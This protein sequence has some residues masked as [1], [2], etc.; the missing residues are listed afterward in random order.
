MLKVCLKVDSGFSTWVIVETSDDASR[1]VRDYIEKNDIGSRAWMGGDVVDDDGNYVTW[2]SYNGR[3]W[4][5]STKHGREA[6][7]RYLS[8]LDKSQ[9]IDMSMAQDDRYTKLRGYHSGLTRGRCGI[10]SE[11]ELRKLIVESELQLRRRNA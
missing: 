8:K 5:P 1:A 3:I 11:S 2:V 4:D 10:F 6:F 9:L 7:E